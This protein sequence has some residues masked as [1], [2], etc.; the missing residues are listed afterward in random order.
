L[1]KNL[2]FDQDVIDF[3]YKQL[4]TVY[5]SFKLKK[6]SV[7]APAAARGGSIPATEGKPEKTG[8]LDKFIMV[9]L[10]YFNAA[11]AFTLPIIHGICFCPGFK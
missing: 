2:R 9:P 3:S 11:A 6:T 7:N 1:N 8:S 10:N 4:L 5:N